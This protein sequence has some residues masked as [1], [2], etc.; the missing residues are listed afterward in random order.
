[1]Y[2]SYFKPHLVIILLSRYINRFN[3]FENIPAFE[4]FTKFDENNTL[5][6]KTENIR[7]YL[8]DSL[9]ALIKDFGDEKGVEYDKI[10]YEKEKKNKKD[11]IGY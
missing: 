3:L 4:S 10:F 11:L 9:A 1:M 7:L 5:E 6:A 8:I 2:Y